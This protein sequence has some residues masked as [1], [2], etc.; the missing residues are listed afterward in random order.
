MAADRPPVEIDQS[1]SLQ[2][3]LFIDYKF[4]QRKD[5][6]EYSIEVKA[7][8]GTSLYTIKSDKVKD[9]ISLAVLVAEKMA[10]DPHFGF[11]RDQRPYRWLGNRWAPVEKWMLSIG[12]S[13]H[14]L[15]RTSLNSNETSL[16]AE[17]MAAWQANSDYPS[18]GLDLRAFG[19]CPG[20]PF[21][22]GVLVSDGRGEELIR[23]K[24]VPH[25]P[26]NLNL[27]VLPLPFTSVQSC[28]SPIGGI[29]FAKTPDGKILVVDGD[30]QLLPR[31]HVF[32][33]TLLWKFLRSTLDEDQIE[34]LQCWFGY[35]LVM[36]LFPNAEKMMYLWGDGGNGKSQILWL[37]RGL[38]GEEACAELRLS[39]LRHS[40]NIELLGGKLA[41]IGSEAN[42]NTEIERLKALISREPLSVNPKYRDPYKLV[43][44]CL[45]TQASNRAPRFD[46]KS[47]AISRRMIS[48]H[49]T[50]S[51]SKSPDKSEDIAQK[52]LETEYNFLVAFAL[53]GVSLIERSNGFK[54]LESIEVESETRV[55][56]GNHFEAFSEQLEYGR[57]EVSRM[58][59]HRA[60]VHWCKTAGAVSAPASMRDL[61]EQIERIAAKSKKVI[62][63][64]ARSASYKP[65]YWYDQGGTRV[66][67][68]PELTETKKPEVVRGFRFNNRNGLVI[69]QPLPA[70]SRD[71]NLFEDT[72]VEA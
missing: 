1:P 22:D 47:D 36:N 55:A 9:R 28:F 39:D 21:Q 34:Q 43:P 16:T 40:P 54:V 66:A 57:F 67:V 68:V 25:R 41:M 31:R 5:T 23:P 56:E 30:A 58:E 53:S 33:D 65:S 20:I 13:M 61:L 19:D 42:T 48:M 14:A 29:E 24:L 10:K 70:G 12:Y 27:H 18:E 6:H 50:R 51:F 35:H 71:A 69:G 2:Q 15:A 46:D 49:L 7:P 45:I 37:L 72:S 60:Y 8:D 11:G 17:A 62:K 4:N 26:E 52:I 32:D 64:D 38:V 44:E 3:F 63:L 59:L